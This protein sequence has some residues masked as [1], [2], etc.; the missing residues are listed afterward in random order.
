MVKKSSQNEGLGGGQLYT[1][2]CEY[3]LGVL[4][5]AVGE[6]VQLPERL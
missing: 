1:Y 2:K 6:D 4:L 3:D 5:D